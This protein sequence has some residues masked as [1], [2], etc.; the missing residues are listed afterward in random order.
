LFSTKSSAQFQEGFVNVENGRL[1]Y[2]KQGTGRPLLF[3][4]GL[5][6]DHQMWNDQIS[7]FATQFTCIT[8]DLR[9]FGKSTVPS[10][11]YSFHE[12]LNVLLDSLHIREPVT[13]IAL[14]M[15]GKAAVNFSLAYPERT[16]ALILADVAIDGYNFEEFDLKPIFEM[17][18]AKGVDSAN[19]LFLNNEVFAYTRKSNVVFDRVSD[20]VLHY[21]GWLW[22]HQNPIK[23]LN[24]VAIQQLDRIKAPV[25]I[26]TGENDIQDFQ[27][28]AEILHKNIKQSEI[29]KIRNAGHMCNMENSAAFNEFAFNFLTTGQ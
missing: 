4:H 18:R 25:L 29:R 9:G 6:L 8:V 21:S 22:I 3:L 5:C 19:Q 2:Q 23:V 27:N 20:M 14:S 17:A 10:A 26:L 7:F 12:D 24:P 11:P 15:G 16:K 13:L 28:I 1:F